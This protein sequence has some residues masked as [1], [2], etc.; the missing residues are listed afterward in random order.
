MRDQPWRRQ[1][2]KGATPYLI[3]A[4]LRD[5]ELYGYQIAQRIR[6]RSDGKFVPSE[7]SLYPT[8]HRLESDGAL[9]ATWRDGERGPRR[10]WYQIT[11]IGLAALAAD[12]AEWQ[13]FSGALNSA[14]RQPSGA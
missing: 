11:P 4:I 13:A 7:G 10:R 3:L 6:E 8:L 5:G 1:L 2:L 14:T 12:A 9:I